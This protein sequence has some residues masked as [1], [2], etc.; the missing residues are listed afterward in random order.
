MVSRLSSDG[1]LR[2][3]SLRHDLLGCWR[4]ALQ[5]SVCAGKSLRPHSLSGRVSCSKGPIGTECIHIGLP[6]KPTG[7]EDTRDPPRSRFAPLHVTTPAGSDP[8][9]CNFPLSSR[10]VDLGC[11]KGH[12][13]VSYPLRE[14]PDTHREGDEG[15]GAGRGDEFCQPGHDS[16]GTRKLKAARSGT[17]PSPRSWLVGTWLPTCSR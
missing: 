2:G 16:C 14:M 6:K 17:T 12:C 4:R 15:A 13:D 10:S 3:Q 5:A 1:H 11:G 9:G 8:C 7:T